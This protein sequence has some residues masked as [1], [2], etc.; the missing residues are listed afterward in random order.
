MRM[1]LRAHTIGHEMLRLWV[2]LAILFGDQEPLR[3]C[4]P[5]RRRGRFLNALNRDWPLHGSCNASLFGRSLVGNR[6]AKPTVRNPYKAVRIGSQL[7]RFRGLWVKIEN[8]G[9]GL[10]LIRR[11]R[12]DIDQ[13]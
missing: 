1:D 10:A 9:D 6:L 3:F 13:R 4:F 2:N 8:L 12:R 7:W 5:C 11:E